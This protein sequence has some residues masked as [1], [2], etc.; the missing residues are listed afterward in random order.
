MYIL[1]KGKEATCI[2]RIEAV[3][4]GHFRIP[5]EVDWDY[6]FPGSNF[7]AWDKE[8][9]DKV[10]ARAYTYHQTGG[11]WQGGRFYR[12]GGNNNTDYGKCEVCGKGGIYRYTVGKK[13]MCW[14]C[15]S[16]VSPSYVGAGHAKCTDCGTKNI[17]CYRLANNA[18]APLICWNCKDKRVNAAL[19]ETEKADDR[20]ANWDALM[21]TDDD[22]TPT[23]EVDDRPMPEGC[24]ACG[25]TKHILEYYA[26]QWLCWDCESKAKLDDA[27][28]R[29]DAIRD[30]QADDDLG[31]FAGEA[32]DAV[33][34]ANNIADEPNGGFL[35]DEEKEEEDDKSCTRC[36]LPASFLTT[37]VIDGETEYICDTCLAEDRDDPEDTF[38]ADTEEEE[39]STGGFAD[40]EEE[41]EE[42]SHEPD[43]APVVDVDP[44]DRIMGDDPRLP[45]TY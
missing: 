7:E 35:D 29:R 34:A 14:Q 16:D 19:E 11:Y 33:D 30:F 31:G 3:P 15:K 25:D 39:E 13:K 22:D 32:V 23:T 9:D 20:Y 40:D 12:S 36:K 2:L 41:E 21:E 18:Q 8:Y 10:E 45:P 5:W 38:G 27:N 37:V 26:G 6:A 28:A 42:T 17:Y 43:E 44:L 24:D 1:G 4:G